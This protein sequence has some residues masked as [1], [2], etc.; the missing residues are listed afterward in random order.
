M[1]FSVFSYYIIDRSINNQ[2]GAACNK[3][4]HDIEKITFY[5]ELNALKSLEILFK[6]RHQWSN[7]L[8][9]PNNEGVKINNRKQYS[10]KSIQSIKSKRITRRASN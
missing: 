9:I 10:K 3:G 8:F 4:K 6:W 5:L 1:L 2:T 7:G